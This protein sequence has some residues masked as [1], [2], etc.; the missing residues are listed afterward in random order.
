M[1]I[2]ANNKERTTFH[3]NISW[4]AKT[5]DDPGLDKVS[6]PSCRLWNKYP[7]RAHLWLMLRLPFICLS[8]PCLLKMIQ[9]RLSTNC[10]VVSRECWKS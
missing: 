7:Q 2:Q 6:V 8:L 10:F 5:C 3:H 1:Q 4:K 9:P